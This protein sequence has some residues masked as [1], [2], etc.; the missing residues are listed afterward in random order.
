MNKC[1]E[2]QFFDPVTLLNGAKRGGRKKIKENSPWRSPLRS[3]SRG[4]LPVRGTEPQDGAKELAQ[5]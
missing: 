5:I 4:E 2:R 3:V 1:R